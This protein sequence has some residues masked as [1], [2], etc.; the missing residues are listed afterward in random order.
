MKT[1]SEPNDSA[2]TLHGRAS[3]RCSMEN[4]MT[5]GTKWI[6]LVGVIA[7]TTFTLIGCAADPSAD[8]P[9]DNAGELDGPGDPAEE[10]IPGE[11]PDPLRVD[12][13]RNCVYV[14]WCDQPN[15]PTGTVCRVYSGCPVNQTT[16]QAYYRECD[17]DVKAV[18]GRPILPM[19]FYPW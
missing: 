19:W 12:K 9:A 13:A 11:E 1:N 4:A 6:S 18:C 14:Q 5:H 17:A 16:V 8:G 10:G 2:S 3:E 7:A 15:S